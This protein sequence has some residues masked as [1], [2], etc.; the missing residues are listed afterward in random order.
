MTTYR[1]CTLDVTEDN[2]IND[3]WR[4]TDT[5]QLP[6]EPTIPQV[7]EQLKA[8]GRMASNWNEKYVRLEEDGDDYFVCHDYTGKYKGKKVYLLRK[9]I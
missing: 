5:L 8:L 4:T 9:E 6:D 2:E 3:A 1:L 7:C